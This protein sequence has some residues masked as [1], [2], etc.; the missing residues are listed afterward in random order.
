MIKVLFIISIA[1]SA[2]IFSCTNSKNEKEKKEKEETKVE[3]IV[4]KAD[5][6]IYSFRA[7]SV[8]P[9]YHRSY[10]I[11]VTETNLHLAINSYGDTLLTKD[12]TFTKEKLDEVKEPVEKFKRRW[13]Y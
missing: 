9:Q 8:A 6:I 7:G 11:A 12:W 3:N 4:S 13:Q 2:T 5:K 1:A 10:S